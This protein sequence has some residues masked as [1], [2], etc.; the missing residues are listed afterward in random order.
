MEGSAMEETKLDLAK[1]SNG[2]Y[3]LGERLSPAQV[4][5][6]TTKCIRKSGAAEY[7]KS[8]RNK[9]LQPACTLPYS[10]SLEHTRIGF[11]A[12]SENLCCLLA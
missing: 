1:R 11:R 9:T 10:Y 3:Y 2:I 12:Q 5:W 8:F 6:Q 7:L 4:R